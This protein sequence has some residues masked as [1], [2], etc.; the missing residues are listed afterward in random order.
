MASL[1]AAGLSVTRLY[2]CSGLGAHL[3]EDHL[4]AL[5]D[6]PERWP[7]WREQLLA[8]ADHPTI[9]GASNHLLAVAH[10]EA[11]RAGL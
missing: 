7:A 4:V 9:V 2:G 8:T 3:Q 11:D 6:D 5:M 10:R 1:T